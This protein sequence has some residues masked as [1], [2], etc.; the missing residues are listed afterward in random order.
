[1]ARAAPYSSGFTTAAL[2]TIDSH[3][4]T[5]PRSPRAVSR[6]PRCAISVSPAA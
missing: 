4:A 3:V 2:A 1:M 6:T 5:S